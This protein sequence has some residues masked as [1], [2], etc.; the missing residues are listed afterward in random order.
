MY[1]AGVTLVLPTSSDDLFDVWEIETILRSSTPKK[2]SEEAI[3]LSKSLEDWKTLG[4]LNQ[5][6]LY[7]VR[8]IHTHQAL[9]PVVEGGLA[10]TRIPVKIGTINRQE[11]QMLTSYDEVFVS[12]GLMLVEKV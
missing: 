2:A 6:V 10:C 5:P 7:G 12:Y 8:Y 9:P 4:Y 3:G 1:C 11:L